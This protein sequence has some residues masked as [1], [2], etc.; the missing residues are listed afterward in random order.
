VNYCSSLSQLNLLF[1]GVNRQLP[2]GGV[3]VFDYHQTSRL[4]EF[5]EPFDEEGVV[6]D[7][8][9]WWHIESEPPR[10]THT[11]TIYGSNYPIT[12]THQQYIFELS[13][14]QKLLL[15]N[16]FRWKMIESSDHGDLYMDEKWMIKAIKEKSL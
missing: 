7:I 10:L 11:I 12:E 14:L 16:G 8:G 2:I 5:D 4:S 9:Y 15:D 13:D 6:T 3:F 1:Q